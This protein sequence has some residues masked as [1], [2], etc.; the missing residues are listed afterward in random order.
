MT[1]IKP[2]PGVYRG[3]QYRSQ[4]E[5]AWAKYW[6]SNG[7][8]YTYI[9]E[10]HA[11]FRITRWDFGDC[12]VKPAKPAMII[13]ALNKWLAAIADESSEEGNGNAGHTAVVIAGGPP[14]E[15]ELPNL[16]TATPTVQ[17]FWILTLGSIKKF[18]GMPTG[19]VRCV[20][21][22]RRW[23]LIDSDALLA[24][25]ITDWLENA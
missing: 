24:A 13:K 10:P 4:L 18:T 19:I 21:S 11:D 22:E 25:S 16:V 12:E 15:Y 23:Y 17:G 14:S 2:K 1:V 9:D 7:I 3:V 6:D 8:E 5:I 20:M